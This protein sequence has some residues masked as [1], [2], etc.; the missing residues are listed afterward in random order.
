MKRSLCFVLVIL[1]CLSLLS[2]GEK[3]VEET[4]L[5]VPDVTEEP[6]TDTETET[7]EE[8]P[9]VDPKT[10]WNG[11]LVHGGEGFY[12]PERDY[13]KEER[14]KVC[15]FAY[16]EYIFTD[17]MDTA[18]EAWFALANVE[19]DGVIHSKG[20]DIASEIEQIAKEYDG[21]VILN[22]Y[23]H[24]AAIVARVL[25]E[26]N[27]S[28]I[29]YYDMRDYSREERPLLC[30]TVHYYTAGFSP[31]V[32]GVAEYIESELN[33]V[34][35]EKIGIIYG[36]DSY[37][38]PDFEQIF[39][40]D[41][42]LQMPEFV[43]NCH[44]VDFNTGMLDYIHLESFFEKVLDENPEVEYW[45]YVPLETNYYNK[46]RDASAVFARRG[47]EDK[48][49]IFSM[50][51]PYDVWI[52]D[53]CTFF[54]KVY[55]CDYVIQMEPLA[56]GLCALMRGEATPE[57]LWAEYKTDGE[58]YAIYPDNTYHE[59]TRYN[60]KDYFAKVNEYVGMEYYVLN[61]GEKTD[62]AS[63]DVPPVAPDYRY[64][65]WNVENYPEYSHFYYEDVADK[66]VYTT[67]PSDLSRAPTRYNRV[68][69]LSEISPVIV[70]GE[71]IDVRYVDA[72]NSG[73]LNMA[74]TVYDIKIAECVHGEYE[75]G[76][77]IS[78]FEYGGYIRSETYNG[79][80]HT[81]DFGEVA[82]KPKLDDNEIVVIKPFADAP[83]LEIGDECVMFLSKNPLIHHYGHSWKI[84]GAFTGRVVVDDNGMVSR[85]SED[86]VW[87]EW[88][89]LDELLE[90]A[91]NTHFNENAVITRDLYCP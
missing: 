67:V 20:F 3:P 42:A 91:R 16:G 35:D 45:I 34:T 6:V 25:E 31:V 82:L 13:S 68:T 2:C 62:E 76:D 22:I 54:E 9:P 88:G 55:S 61:S 7:K 43:D 49:V 73:V 38:R 57:T 14:F 89:T 66:E 15:A 90:I 27:C 70:Y 10:I 69:S 77:I 4:T 33:D 71:I 21:V 52:T 11:T 53:E 29:S 86:G 46:Y 40:Y 80:Y 48:A 60:Y 23:E 8:E 78:V 75:V 85:W 58:K 56:F 81:Y 74:Y 50:N 18:L 64:E 59:I 1:M 44:F 36:H 84:T 79:G 17:Q 63:E 47:F 19:Y 72:N 26:N 24:D 30:P 37:L 32:S 28:F 65:F 5:T 51:S 41:V 83:A 12:D 87:E 39:L